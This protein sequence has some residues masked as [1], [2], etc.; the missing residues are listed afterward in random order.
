[1]YELRRESIVMHTFLFSGVHGV[2][3]GF[4]LQKVKNSLQQYNVYTASALI[5]RYQS[6]T[7]AGYK[8]VHDVNKNQN[9]LVKA[10]AEIKMN[11]E[12][13]LILDGHLCILNAEGGIE[14]VPESFFRKTQIMG[15]ILLQDEPCRIFDRIKKRD[16]NQ[17]SVQNIERMQEEEL[18][19]AEELN[20]KLQIKHVIIT[21]ECTEKQ[22]EKQIREI[23]GDSF[24]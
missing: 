22:F 14:R 12:N 24:E 16:D 20:V 10:I 5:E 6:S 3:K 4:F 18:K 17:I 23:G 8:R 2:G 11:S 13:D 19:Y 9:I 1:M 7:D 21:H 15:I